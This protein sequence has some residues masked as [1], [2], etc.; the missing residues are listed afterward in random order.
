M[1]LAAHPLSPRTR[2][3]GATSLRSCARLRLRGYPPLRY[4][5]FSAIF[6]LASGASPLRL[7]HHLLAVRLVSRHFPP[8]HVALCRIGSRAAPTLGCPSAL[9]RT[10]RSPIRAVRLRAEYRPSPLAT[11]SAAPDASRH[12][13]ALGSPVALHLARSR[14]SSIRFIVAALPRL[15][16]ALCAA[17]VQPRLSQRLKCTCAAGIRLANER[18][19]E[20]CEAKSQEPAPRG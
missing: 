7:H 4:A 18:S 20:L 12:S 13:C 5:H 19:E 16:A 9:R 1:K 15:R 11:V 6:R 2:R 14:Y 17:N 8:L 10:I 3:L